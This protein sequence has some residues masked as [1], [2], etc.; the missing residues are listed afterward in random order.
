MN[1]SYPH[2]IVRAGEAVTFV[3]LLYSMRSIERLMGT[4]KFS[5][6]VT[7]IHVLAI[8]LQLGA[9]ALFPALRVL[10]AGPYAL[11]FALL[12]FYLSRVS[13]RAMSSI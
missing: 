12:Y 11:S 6:F 13:P 4:A 7:L 8:P 2:R 1:H 9:L 3:L 5:S 10:P